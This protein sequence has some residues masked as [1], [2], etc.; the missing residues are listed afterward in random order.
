[1][2][3]ENAGIN[4]DLVLNTR[5]GNMGG[6]ADSMSGRG[7][8][9]GGMDDMR[10]RGSMGGGGIGGGGMDSGYGG[11]GM[12]MNSRG[13]GM[14][15]G[16][17]GRMNNDESLSPGTE[18]VT[19]CNIPLPLPEPMV[20]ESTPAAQRLFVVCQPAAVP[21]R[22]L[23][24]AFSRFANLISIFLLTGM[25]ESLSNYASFLYIWPGLATNIKTCTLMRTFVIS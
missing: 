12:G 15:N 19:Y 13:G 23:R 1:M 22:I 16:M 9:G 7:M 4:P 3:L 21:E 14:D 20:P 10:M 8:G 17:G 5:A 11:G 24:D 6:G 25:Y 18:R 2:V